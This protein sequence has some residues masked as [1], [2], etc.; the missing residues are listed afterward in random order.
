MSGFSSA[1]S[2]LTARYAHTASLLPDGKVYIGGGG[3]DSTTIEDGTVVISRDELFDAATDRFQQAGSVNRAFH[4]ATVLQNG[5]VLFTGGMSNDIVDANATVVASADLLKAGGSTLQPTGSMSVARYYHVATL[6]QDGMVLITGGYDAF[7]AGT[8]T[9]ELYD[10]AKGTFT[11]IG[12]MGVRRGSHFA[13]LLANGK[14]LIS[15]GGVANVELFDPETNSF[16][17]AGTTASPTVGAATLLADGKVLISGE[18]NSDF[19]GPGPSELYNPVTGTFTPTGTMAIW[20]YSY[21]TTLLPD[22]TVLLAGGYI[23]GPG[24]TPGSGYTEVIVADT[25]IYDPSTGAFNRGPTMRRA[26]HMHTA[27]LLPDGSVLLVGGRGPDYAPTGS[28]EIYQ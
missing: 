1:G 8:K 17:P 14:V 9:A 13:T 26:Q 4:T 5:D 23:K 10:P 18:M 19:S 11:R 21:T 25:E 22:G 16:T 7:G 27:T 15:G 12:D 3:Y 2:L 24:S 28:A 20:R 6:L